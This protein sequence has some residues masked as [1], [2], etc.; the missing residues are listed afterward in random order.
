MIDQIFLQ[1]LIIPARIGV[2]A[3]EKASAQNISLD[4]TLNI[5]TR[6]A[7]SSDC[8]ADTLDYAALA[9]DIAAHCLSQHVELVETLAQQIADICLRDQRVQR[10]SLT[11]AKPEALAN[12]ASVGVRI[13]REQNHDAI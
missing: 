1:Q 7:T 12:A 13:T 3:H 5:D 10:V 11:L 8:L 2:L 9:Q 6:T 4:I